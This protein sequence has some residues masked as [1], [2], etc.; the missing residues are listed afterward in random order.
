[1]CARLSIL[2][3]SSAWRCLYCT[4]AIICYC[5][6]SFVQNLFRCLTSKGKIED[7]D[8]QIHGFRGFGTLFIFPR[9]I[10]YWYSLGARPKAKFYSST[11]PSSNSNHF[12][13]S[14]SRTPNSS[15]PHLSPQASSQPPR[16]D[17]LQAGDGEASFLPICIIVSTSQPHPSPQH[18]IFH[19]LFSLCSVS[20]LT[21]F[22][23]RHLYLNISLIR[24]PALLQSI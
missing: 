1:V 5:I 14:Q 17:I 9:S 23:S 4:E 3:T 2:S 19:H 20:A 6:A 11:I 22:S 18:K 13:F 12:P 15:Y 21:A 7:W 10:R 8:R 24:I 16:G